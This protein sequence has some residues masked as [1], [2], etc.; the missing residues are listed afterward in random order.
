MV[1][2]SQLR[3]NTQY[4]SPALATLLDKQKR[5]FKDKL[6][7][8][9]GMQAKLHLDPNAQLKFHWPRNVPYA[10]CGSVEQ[11]LGCPEKHGVIEP[12]DFTDWAAPIV[13]VMKKDGTIQVCGD[14]MQAHG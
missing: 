10:I 5:L 9:H 6:G 12:V 7:T 8:I 1:G 4:H 11:A 2:W 14:Y 3:E 13:L